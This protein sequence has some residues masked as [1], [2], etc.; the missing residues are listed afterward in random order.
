MNYL[1]CII[2]ILIL[3]CLY[4]IFNKEVKETFITYNKDFKTFHKDYGFKMKDNNLIYKNNKLI[5]FT[6]TL[7]QLESVNITSDKKKTKE[8]F[9]KYNI[10]TPKGLLF[11]NKNDIDIFIKKLI[12]N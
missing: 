9:Y 6:R 10:P 1:S 12:V 4:F 2:F 8:L 3:Y 7:N 11:N 5:P